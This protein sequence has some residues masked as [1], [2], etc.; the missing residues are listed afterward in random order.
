MKL[1][2][3]ADLELEIARQKL[4]LLKFINGIIAAGIIGGIFLAVVQV[5]KAIF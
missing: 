2:E 5:V 1:N 3:T 4:S